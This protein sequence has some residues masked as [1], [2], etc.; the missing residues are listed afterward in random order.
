MFMRICRLRAAALLI[1]LL[2]PVAAWAQPEVFVEPLQLYNAPAL[3]GLAPGL[4]AMLA[5]R[6][7]GPGYAVRAH[8][9]PPKGAADWRV[10][11]SL[12]R[13]G[14]T[15]SL[16]A[17]LVSGA[18]T[19][20]AHTYQTTDGPDGLAPALEQVAERL[21]QELVQATAPEAA[22]PPPPGISL[23]E[24]LGRQRAGPEIPGEALSLAVADADGDGN[25]EILLLTAETITAFRDQG[26]QLTQVWDSPAPR[27]FK[28]TTLSVG[29]VDGNGL[30]E[31]FVA[32]LSN[33]SPVTQALE[34]FGSA[35]GPKAERTL[36]FLRAVSHPEQGVLLLGM[37]RGL[38]RDLFSRGVRQYRWDGSRYEDVGRYPVTERA[39]GVNVDFLRLGTP[40]QVLAVITTQDDR[41][42]GVDAEGRSVFELEDAL[43]GTRVQLFGEEQTPGMMDEDIVKIAAH[44]VGYRSPRGEDYLLVHKN[45]GGIGRLF[46]RITGFSSGHLLA[47]RWDGLGL[48]NT[49]QSAKY[50]GYIAD[51][52]LARGG[53]GQGATLFAALVREGAGL[54][55]RPTTRLVAYDLP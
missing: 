47:F 23:Q 37:A 34:W 13:L 28:P 1:A 18:G 5:S 38:G 36:A 32:G 10:Q 22:P 53:A 8:G 30:P 29:D 35:L 27:D 11:T 45:T 52:G 26:G 43:K 12:T 14:T 6:L 25:L 24:A 51:L 21:R 4:R 55:Q 48:T 39:V 50:S 49:A 19:A 9:E 40:P 3:E 16:D 44:T 20:G 17:A 54:F 46:R 2:V 33:H 31:L 42:L 15:Y 7:E 41:L